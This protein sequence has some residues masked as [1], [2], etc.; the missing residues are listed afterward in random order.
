SVERAVCLYGEMNR[1]TARTY[2]ILLKPEALPT[3]LIALIHP[4]ASTWLDQA[5]IGAALLDQLGKQQTPSDRPERQAD[6]DAGQPA[7]HS[8]LIAGLY[9]D[10]TVDL[11]WPILRAAADRPNLHLTFLTG[12]DAASLAWFTAKQYVRTAPDV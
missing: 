12:R 2:G 6:D 11:V 8:L 5:Q 1:P 3:G 4:F 9:K 10:F 7:M